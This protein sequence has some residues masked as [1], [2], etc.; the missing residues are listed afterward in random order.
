[1][2]RQLPYLAMDGVLCD[3][4]L[5]I[6]GGKATTKKGDKMKTMSTSDAATVRQKPRCS[7]PVLG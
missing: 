4:P 6:F 7:K 5:P 1:M 3:Y 2:S